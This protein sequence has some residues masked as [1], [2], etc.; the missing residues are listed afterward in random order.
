MK[1]CLVS[2]FPPSRRGLNEY[3]YHVAQE[4]SRNP[5]LSLT[6]LADELP[7]P[8]PELEDYNVIRCWSFNSHS[9]PLRIL[10]AVREFKPDVVWLNLG[11]ARFGDSP[12]AAFVG[13]CIPALL[14]LSGFYTHVTLHQL[15]ETVDL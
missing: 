2:A 8:Q 6:I 7:T 11:L 4:L 14:R 5:L 1:I 12:L 9:N 15:M 13:L 10:R 3:G